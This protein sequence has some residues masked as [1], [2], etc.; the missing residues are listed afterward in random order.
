MRNLA[1]RKGT[2]KGSITSSPAY[3]VAELIN[4]SEAVAGV[5]SE[6]M[7]GAFY[8]TDKEVLTVKEAQDLV[9]QFMKKKVK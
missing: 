8:G 3:S 1:E 9:Q 5:K 7:A 6:V 4:N 2:S